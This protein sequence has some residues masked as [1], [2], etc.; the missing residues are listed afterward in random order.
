MGMW[1]KFLKRQPAGNRW[2]HCAFC[3]R[4][5]VDGLFMLISERNAGPLP[6]KLCMEHLWILR[7]AGSQGRVHGP[8][9]VR[10]WLTEEKQREATT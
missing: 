5:P 10:W 1:R 6:A 8:T 9:G 4:V 3:H 2:L 7:R